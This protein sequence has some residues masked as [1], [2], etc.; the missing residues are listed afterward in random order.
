MT[1]ILNSN[2]YGELEPRRL[3]KFE[4]RIGARLPEEYRAFLLAHNGG[5]PDPSDFEIG[6][7]DYSGIHGGFYGLHQGPDYCRLDDNY[8]TFKGRIPDDLLA[9][10]D[11]DAGNQICIGI[12]G[13]SKGQIFFWDH[14]KEIHLENEPH[15]LYLNFSTF[16]SNLEKWSPPGERSLILVMI[17]NNDVEGIKK[18]LDAG[19][20]IEAAVPLDQSTIEAG[21]SLER[22]LLEEAA[23]HNKPEIIEL[24]FKRGAKLKGALE[25]ATRNLEFYEDYVK[26]V[27]LLKKL[28]G[29]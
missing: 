12:K 23:I 26:S 25:F 8:D 13:K 17:E 24:L 9:I 15:L 6:P 16:L 2:Q 11:D 1:K 4:T 21:I 18:V 5:E 27:A 3:E 19:F 22:T 28:Y 29:Q 7:N 10:A 14:E 20:D